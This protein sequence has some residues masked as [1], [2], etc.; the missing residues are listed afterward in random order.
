MRPTGTLTGN[1][2]WALWLLIACCLSGCQN[3]TY[4]VEE[5]RLNA[6]SSDALEVVRES[7][8]QR[9]LV[10][11]RSVRRDDSS[12]LELPANQVRLRSKRAR[13][14]WITAALMTTIGGVLTIGGAVFAIKNLCV[15]HCG[16]PEDRASKD[17]LFAG[18]L[19]TS[20]LGDV[21]LATATVLWGVAA[22]K[23]F[24]AEELAV[25]PSPPSTRE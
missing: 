23:E 19:Y 25:I 8:G 15:E 3:R 5:S 2:G 1:S 12:A 21:S 17:R 24:R 13:S 10:H 16:R 11:P 7:D 9:L 22:G 18:G 6:G 14:L 20:I 4:L